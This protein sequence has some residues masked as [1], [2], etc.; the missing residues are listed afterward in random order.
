MTSSSETKYPL[1]SSG[2][3]HVLKEQGIEESFI[4]KLR[5]LKYTY[6]PHIR[7][8]TTLEHNFR[9]K[10]EALNRVRLTDGEFQRLLDEL[11]TPDVFTA[12]RVIR[13]KNDFVRDDGTPLAYTLV[14]IKDWCKNDFEVTHHVLFFNVLSNE[15][16]NLLNTRNWPQYCLN[17]SRRTTDYLLVRQKGDTPF[18]HHVAALVALHEASQSDKIDTHHFNTLRSVLE[19]TAV[20]HG[21]GHFSSCIKKD[22]NDADGILHQRFVDLLSHGKYSLYEPLEMGEET[23]D[24]FRQ[25]L[26]EFIAEYPFNPVLF[27]AAPAQAAAVAAPVATASAT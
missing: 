22:P 18:F 21:Y 14:N 7:D 3:T 5:S 19:K 20:F 25:I 13:E 1:G 8:R 17:R 16:K 26:Q 6:C 4:E 2:E 10:F 15:I 27:P 9:Q 12:A 23:R 24:Y 11:I